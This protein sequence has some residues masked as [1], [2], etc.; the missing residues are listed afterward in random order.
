MKNQLGEFG[1]HI[2]LPGKFSKDSVS[3]LASFIHNEKPDLFYIDESVEVAKLANLFGVPYVYARMKNKKKDDVENCLAYAL[4]LFNIAPYDNV[5]EEDWYKKTSFYH[6]TK[7]Y[8][9]EKHHVN[10]KLFCMY[11]E[12]EVCLK[13]EEAL[14]PLLFKTF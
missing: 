9:R 8:L 12:E 14:K 4:S 10:N 13:R 1:Q 6:K 2:K 5:H 7:Y 11:L 3:I